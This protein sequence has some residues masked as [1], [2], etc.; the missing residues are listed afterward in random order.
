MVGIRATQLQYGALSL[1]NMDEYGID[2]EDYLQ[3]AQVELANRKL[4]FILKR[5]LTCVNNCTEF[6]YV[7]L[8]KLS[9]EC[10]PGIADEFVEA[11]SD[12]DLDESTTTTTYTFNDH[13]EDASLTKTMLHKTVWVFSP[14]QQHERC[15]RFVTTTMKSFLGCVV[16]TKPDVLGIVV[17]VVSFT[18]DEEQKASIVNKDGAIAIAFKV[19][20]DVQ[21]IQPYSV[22]KECVV[23]TIRYVFRS[24]NSANRAMELHGYPSC[25]I[26]MTKT[27]NIYCIA[28]VDMIGS[29]NAIV[30]ALVSFS[31][32]KYKIR[33]D[34]MTHTSSIHKTFA[35]DH[36]EPLK[37]HCKIHVHIDS[38]ITYK[39]NASSLSL[40]CFASFANSIKV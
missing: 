14:E 38:V 5:P 9:F 23:C 12:D 2:P 25:F 21:C 17:N 18:I 22:T 26:D 8:N 27:K 13:I 28:S 19:F 30:Y 1:I 15:I 7:S 32:E 3:R 29:S 39:E 33:D 31:P 16:N 10:V 11:P 34:V 36:I 35:G 20:V 37:K 4:A 40:M 6:E 24:N